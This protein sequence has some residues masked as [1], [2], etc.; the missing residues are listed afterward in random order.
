M[1]RWYAGDYPNPPV[2]V[3][4][5]HGWPNNDAEG[6]PQYVNTHFD[7]EREAWESVWANVEAGVSIERRAVVQLTAELARAKARLAKSI[8]E[9]E[10]FGLAYRKR[11]TVAPDQSGPKEPA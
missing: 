8:E 1:K 4:C 11:W 7:D 6:R 3:E 10:T 2:Q 9:A 5:K